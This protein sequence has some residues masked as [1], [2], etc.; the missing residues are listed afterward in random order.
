MSRYVGDLI[1]KAATI[2]SGKGSNRLGLIFLACALLVVGMLGFLIWDSAAEKGTN[3]ALKA[4]LFL[5]GLLF[6]LASIT[7]GWETQGNKKFA[8]RK[9]A[10]TK[11]A[12]AILLSVFGAFSVM[13]DVLALFEPRAAVESSVGAIEK[14]VTDIGQVSSRID[15]TTQRTSRDTQMIRH[16][17]QNAGLI[18]GD[19]L[20]RQKLPGIWGESGCKVTYRFSI[21]SN[22]VALTSI[23]NQPGM[24]DY[25][26]TASIV[27]EQGNKLVTS[28]TSPERG[29]TVELTYSSDGIQERL[30]HHDKRNDVMQEFV[31]CT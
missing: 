13:T 23:R 15:E 17:L 25:N 3:A 16:G 26:A 14:G 9:L 8:F 6:A 27:S 5:V 4:G 19:S 18:D 31:R 10:G 21:Q 20:I 7:V 1:R 30:V 2:L 29:I 11:V 24:H 28:S 22:A 12:G